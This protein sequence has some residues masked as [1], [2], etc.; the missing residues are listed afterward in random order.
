MLPRPSHYEIL[1]ITK[2][3]DQ[4]TVKAAYAR[5]ARL[6]HPD[7]NVGSEWLDKL[8]PTQKEYMKE[9][10]ERIKVARDV[11][12]NANGRFQYD[13]IC[14]KPYTEDPETKAKNNSFCNEW[15]KLKKLRETYKL[16]SEIAENPDAFAEKAFETQAELERLKAELAEQKKV[17]ADLEKKNQSLFRQVSDYERLQS[18]VKSSASIAPTLFS[19]E[20]KKP[21]PSKENIKGLVG[22]KLDVIIRDRKML[23]SEVHL[24]FDNPE[25][26]K[27]GRLF[28]LANR[29]KTFLF[30]TQVGK[31]PSLRMAFDLFDTNHPLYQEVKVAGEDQGRIILREFAKLVDITKLSKSFWN[32]ETKKFMSDAETRPSPAPRK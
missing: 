26:A 19:S 2:D 21:E 32:L 11:L 6:W 22:I 5:L 31:E 18:P 16:K 20:S 8:T 9:L 14:A 28:F 17:N 27:A 7:S 3:A 4:A 23:V 29:E 13:S 15:S 1:G 25:S 10:W 30:A 24:Q 12:S